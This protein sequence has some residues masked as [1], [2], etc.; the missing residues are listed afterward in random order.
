MKTERDE[1][2]IGLSGYLPYGAKMYI[3]PS[4]E[5]GEEGVDNEPL[6]SMDLGYNVYNAYSVYPEKIKPYLRPMSSMTEKER[7][8]MGKAIQ[9]DRI[10]PYGEIKNFGEDSLLLCTIRQSTNLQDW[11]NEHKFD[12]RGWI[13]KGWALP[14]PEGMYC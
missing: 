6:E 3:A 11:L 8:E 4:L 1:R 9:K 13:E 12:Y 10:E 14:A 5:T 7:A 2:I